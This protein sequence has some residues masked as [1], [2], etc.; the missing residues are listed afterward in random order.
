MDGA[1]GNGDTLVTVGSFREETG[2]FG[3]GK[4]KTDLAAYNL[5][6]YQTGRLIGNFSILH[7]A[8][9]ELGRIG[10]CECV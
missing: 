6:N 4:Q 2:T 9:F 7:F 10:A 1:I 3:L 8:G 5:I